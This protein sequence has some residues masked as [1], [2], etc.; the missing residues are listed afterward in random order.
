MYSIC[1]SFLR[2]WRERNPKMRRPK[3]RLRVLSPATLPFNSAMHDRNTRYVYESTC[4]YSFRPMSFIRIKEDF[5]FGRK[6]PRSSRQPSRRLRRLGRLGEALTNLC[7]SGNAA[8]KLKLHS[9]HAR[10]TSIVTVTEAIFTRTERAPKALRIEGIDVF[11]ARQSPEYRRPCCEP[12]PLKWGIW[13]ELTPQS[14]LCA[15]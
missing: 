2:S 5:G 9:G 12:L 13:S 7:T 10:Q 14:V 1:R 6:A 8:S 3:C 15:M 11:Q 4:I